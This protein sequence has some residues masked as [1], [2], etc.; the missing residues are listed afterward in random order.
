MTFRQ[1]ILDYLEQNGLFPEHA[2][3]VLDTTKDNQHFAA[4]NEVLGNSTDGYPIA[5]LAAA[6]VAANAAAV[7]WIDANMP[8]H[9]ARPMFA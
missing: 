4:L 5:M 3:A 1:F 6:Q 8:R 7:A 9:F 2:K